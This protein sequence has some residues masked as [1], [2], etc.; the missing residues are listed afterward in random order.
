MFCGCYRVR[1][2]KLPELLGTIARRLSGPRF[3]CGGVAIAYPWYNKRMWLNAY[4]STVAAQLRRAAQ[5]AK[6]RAGNKRQEIARFEESIKQQKSAL[7]QEE[8][9][10]EG[11]IVGLEDKSQQYTRHAIGQV[12]QKRQEERDK[13]RELNDIRTSLNQ[14]I[15][16]LENLVQ[17]LNSEAKDYEGRSFPYE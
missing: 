9:A 15:D 16:A 7:K 10:L 5:D 2:L 12:R 6:Q 3:I 13:D 8:R 4:Y 14:E 1:Y 17:Q 11:G